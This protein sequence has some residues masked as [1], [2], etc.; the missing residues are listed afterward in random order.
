MDFDF[1]DSQS[2]LAGLCVEIF[3]P[4]L[5]QPTGSLRNDPVWKAA[6]AA[7]LL[8]VLVTEGSGGAGLGAADACVVAQRCGAAGL[9]VPI[10]NA[11]AAL[12]LVDELTS[13]GAGSARIQAAA[14][15][16][17]EG[18]VF[19]PLGAGSAD[20]AVEAPR[21]DSSTNRLIG[22]ALLAPADADLLLVW[23]TVDGA[24]DALVALEARTEAIDIRTVEQ[25]AGRFA[26]YGI[27]DVA[28]DAAEVLVGPEI[29][30][31]KRRS[32]HLELLLNC[33]ELA[34]LAEGAMELTAGYAT[35]RHQFD[36]PIGTFQ[37][38]ATRLADCY[39][40]V[41]TMRWT[42]W[43]AAL[44]YDAGDLDAEAV[45][46]ARVAACE[47]GDRVL[48]AAQ[49]IHGG[50]GVDVSYLLHRYYLRTRHLLLA[51]GGAQRHLAELGRTLAER[52]RR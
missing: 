13:A 24:A 52:V 42:M 38:V 5:P 6:C 36:R 48:A 27:D 10:S 7:G 41:E 1:T 20:P 14:R 35:R 21:L 43:R 12:A 28:V 39:I 25:P 47:G 11:M 37:A 15:A 23:A 49:H 18:T 16:I 44:R 33:A 50:L 51:G 40:D 34:G 19:M 30:R 17:G 26:R 45:A 8:G 2:A 4:A 9:S 3:D 32:W 29:T 31:L 46:I 22:G